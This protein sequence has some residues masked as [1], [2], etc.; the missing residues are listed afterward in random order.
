MPLIW[1]WNVRFITVNHVQGKV[2]HQTFSFLH[3]F[4][5]L[6]SKHHM[7]IGWHILIQ[8]IWIIDWNTWLQSK[9]RPKT[10]KTQKQNPYQNNHLISLSCCFC[11]P[12]FQLRCAHPILNKISI[13]FVFSRMNINQR[14]TVVPNEIFDYIFFSP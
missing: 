14:Q 4:S 5:A 13:K 10:M 7:A 12:H 2:Y 8:N 3:I 9:W 1:L 11:A 6:T